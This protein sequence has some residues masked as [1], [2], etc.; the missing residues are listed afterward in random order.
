M[1]TCALCGST[2]IIR[3][4]HYLPAAFFRRLHSNGR[5]PI[6]VD[7]HSKR[8]QS[9]QPQAHLLCDKC[10]HRFKTQSED[11]VVDCT[12]KTTGGF[13]LRD[14]LLRSR[15]VG[16]MSPDVATAFWYHGQR[17]AKMRHRE[18]TYFAASVFWRGCAYDW[19]LVDSS[20]SRLRFAP[21]LEVEFREFLL[22]RSAFPSSAILQV[23]VAFD[24]FLVGGRLGM[25]FPEEIT[26]RKAAVRQ[27]QPRGYFFFVCGLTF[28]LYFDLGIP[29]G[30]IWGKATSIA[31]PPYPLL[32]TNVRMSEVRAGQ[33]A[34]ESTA[35][36]KGRLARSLTEI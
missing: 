6:V 20:L 7:A 14:L 12:C 27:E 5:P 34:L 13:A 19:S 21:A 24:P 36:P 28:T 10:E 4:S 3:S 16:A 26:P 22:G 9:K 17:L 23:E 11:W 29:A 1:G 33:G 25:I 18:I 8:E 32:L 30:L 31:E 15:P 35:V 2:A